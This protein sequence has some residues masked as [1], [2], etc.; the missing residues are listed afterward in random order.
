VAELAQILGHADLAI[1]ALGKAADRGLI[2][3]VWLEHCSL[4]APL[5]AD[6]SFLAVRDTVAARAARVLAAFRAAVS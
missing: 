6:L 4:F 2:D 3:L 5:A 1:S